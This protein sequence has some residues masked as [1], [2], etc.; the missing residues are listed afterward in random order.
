MWRVLEREYAVGRKLRG[1]L[2]SL[3]RNSKCNVRTE[4]E[5]KK[6]FEVRTG[7]KQGSVLSPI[8]FVSFLDVVIKKV[9]EEIGDLDGDILAYADDLACWSEEGDKLREVVI[10]FANRLREAGL[11]INA[12]KTEIMVVS[13]EEGGR[14]LRI[15]VEGT[16]IKTVEKY[17][18]LGGVFGREGGNV[19][20]IIGRIAQYGGA[21]R[22]VYPIVKDRQMS[23]EVKRAIFEGVLTPI[24]LYGAETWS[25]TTREDSRIQSAEMYVLRAIM[26]KTRRDRQR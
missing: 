20:E 3:Y 24:L 18:Y 1:A 2:E 23:V 19:Q 25:T 7:V 13:R 5:S 8:L 6:W 22:A 17:K 4:Y 26:G 12:E 16:E 15:E 9:R 21:V 11:T 10:C 14:E